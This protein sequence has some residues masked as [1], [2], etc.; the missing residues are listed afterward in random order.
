MA[1]RSTWKGYLK[2]S[3]V[4]IP[5]R[6]F[7]A[8]DSAASISFNQ[9]HGECQTRIKQKR[10][11]HTCDREI[12]RAEIVKGYE[13]DKGRYVV[14]DEEDIAKVRPESTRIINL[15]KFAD[16]ATI[17]P[18][19]LEKSY[20]LAPDGAVASEAFAVM[21]EAMKGK[22]G[23]GRLAISGREHL[24][25]VRPRER[26]LVMHT[27]KRANEVRSMEA[28]DELDG[29]PE[30]VKADEIALAKQVMA[31]FEGDVDLADYT[32]EYKAELRKMIDAKVAGEEFVA[33]PE[34]APEKVVNL[35]EALR[36]SLDQ[37]SASKKKTAKADLPKRA[38]AR[39]KAKKRKV[40]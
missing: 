2:V 33:S 40:G 37:V 36:K 24:V 4:N 26:G 30:E 16:D 32:D 29:L 8:S 14:L 9:L 10:W 17:D 11:C 35:M 25:A 6:V 1:A 7:P 5:I 22:A 31:N 21:R 34:E 15:V 27:L 19:Y 28:I 3:L 39:S 23:I 13:F 18:I 12:D 20:Y 38:A